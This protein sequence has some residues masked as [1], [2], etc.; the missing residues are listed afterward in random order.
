MQMV[1]CRHL[2]CKLTLR[3]ELVL[4]CI[5][6]WDSFFSLSISLTDVKAY[7]LFFNWLSVALFGFH[8][9][10]SDTIS[11]KRSFFYYLPFIYCIIC[12]C[13]FCS[14]GYF[15]LSLYFIRMFFL[16]FFVNN[17][18]SVSIYISIYVCFIAYCRPKNGPHLSLCTVAPYEQI[19][20]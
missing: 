15:G 6:M 13:Y 4:S 5:M 20:P 11:V 12:A 7:F 17:K 1:E 19:S 14:Q 3:C 2:P 8:S 9:I 18:I 16:L 10:F